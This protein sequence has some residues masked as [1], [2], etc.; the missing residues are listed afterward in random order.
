MGIIHLPDLDIGRC[1]NIRSIT[2]GDGYIETL[3]CLDYE[4]VPHVCT[5]P[6]ERHVSSGDYGWGA[7]SISTYTPPK[8]KPWVKPGDERPRSV[9]PSEGETDG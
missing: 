8:P 6:P 1:K 2:H 7:G 4:G 3:R 5:F 9:G